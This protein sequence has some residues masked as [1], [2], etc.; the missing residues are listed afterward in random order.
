MIRESPSFAW[1]CAQVALGLRELPDLA[2]SENLEL[3]ET[4]LIHFD[5]WR[6]KVMVRL[7]IRGNIP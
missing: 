4:A 6:D 7:S 2:K 1:V 3:K 5:E